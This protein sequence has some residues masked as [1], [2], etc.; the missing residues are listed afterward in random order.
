VGRVIVQGDSN[1]V[2][3]QLNGAWGVHEGLYHPLAL[4]A[5]DMLGRLRSL[6]SLKWSGR[7]RYFMLVVK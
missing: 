3:Y 6:S 2:V 1:L 7:H 5:R 4:E